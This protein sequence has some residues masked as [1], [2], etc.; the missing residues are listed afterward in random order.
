MMR[1]IIPG[2]AVAL[3]VLGIGAAVAPQWR[4]ACP[5]CKTC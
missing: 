4:F 2:V 5:L 1:R 3:L